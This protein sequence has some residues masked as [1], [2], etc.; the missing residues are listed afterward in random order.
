[1]VDQAKI[2]SKVRKNKREQ[3]QINGRGSKNERASKQ[4]YE[5]KRK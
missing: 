1:M 4:K 2:N 5:R 3:A